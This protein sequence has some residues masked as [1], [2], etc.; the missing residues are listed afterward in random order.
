MR[1][2]VQSLVISG[3]VGAAWPAAGQVPVGALAIDGRR[4]D[5]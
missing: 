3:M 2:V 5:Q 1:A 4:G